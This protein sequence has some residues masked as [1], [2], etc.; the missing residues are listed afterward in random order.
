MR[1]D[2]CD[3]LD[4]NIIIILLLNQATKKFAQNKEIGFPANVIILYDT[5]RTGKKAYSLLFSV[6]K[7]LPRVRGIFIYIY[8]FFLERF[9]NNTVSRGK[10]ADGTRTRRVNNRFHEIGVTFGYYVARA[11]ERYVRGRY[12]E[13]DAPAERASEICE[14]QTSETVE[15][16]G[17]SQ[18][19]GAF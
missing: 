3:Y 2:A 11:I 8:F 16:P 15:T 13:V 10:S 14:F 4:K 18:A 9:V 12:L 19:R 5:N 6:K 17:N 7:L 1:R